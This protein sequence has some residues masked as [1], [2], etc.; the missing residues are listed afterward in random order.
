VLWPIVAGV[1]AQ[2]FL[3]GLF[4]FGEVGARATHEDVEWTV[5]T[6]GVLALLLAIAGP[7]TKEAM[8]GTLGL[9]VLALALWLALRT[10]A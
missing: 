5:H 3:A 10:R 9:A 4:N 8:L 1:V 7:R 2:V 6:I